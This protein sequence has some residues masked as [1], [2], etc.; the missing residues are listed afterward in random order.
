MD[1]DSDVL[2]L[3]GGYLRANGLDTAAIGDGRTCLDEIKI[4]KKDL[5][6]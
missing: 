1:N 5:I 3:F 2:N 6:L 4:C